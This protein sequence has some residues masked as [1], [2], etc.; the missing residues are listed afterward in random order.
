MAESLGLVAGAGRLPNLIAREARRQ[1]WRVVVFALSDPAGLEAC[2]RV[3][4]LRLDALGPA[5]EVI[6]EEG[7]R[8]AVLA[9]RVWRETVLEDAS[10]DPWAAQVLRA[11]ADWTDDGLLTGVAGALEGLGIAILDQRRFVA[12]WLAPEGLLGGPPAAPSALADVAHGLA[13]ARELAVRRIG[14]TVVVRTGAVGAV[15]ALEGTDAAIRRGLALVGPGAV[16]VKATAPGHDYRFDVPAVGPET[17]AACV[18]GGA[19]VLAV[20]AGRVLVLERPEAEAR[21]GQ[22]GLSLLGVRGDPG[23]A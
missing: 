23:P 22:G 13:L 19:A 4:A 20:E 21:A 14:Q 15:E 8:A 12:P 18:A 11:S 5:L 9:G 6:S 3:V 7:I 2:E 1:G 10:T 17:V 16:V